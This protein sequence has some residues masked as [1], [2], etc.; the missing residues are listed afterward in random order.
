MENVLNYQF[1]PLIQVIQSLQGLAPQELP[2]AQEDPEIGTQIYSSLSDD[3]T[4]HIPIIVWQL[5]K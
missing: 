3:I 1:L 5:E 2:E 4:S